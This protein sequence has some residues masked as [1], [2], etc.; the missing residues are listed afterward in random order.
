[1][2]GKHHTIESKRKIGEANKIAL[3]G[4]KQ[5]KETINK[6]IESR[7]WYKHS[8]DTKKKIGNA[9]K[10]NM[11]GFRQKENTKKKIGKTIR[12]L[13]KDNKYKEKMHKALLGRK[14]SEET[15]IKI[16]KARKGKKH[17]D[18]TKQKLSKA[19]KGLLSKEKH[20]NWRGGKSFEPYSVDWTETL[21]RSIRERDNY[22]CQLCNQ[23]GNNVHHIDYDKKNC[24]TYNLITLCR[25]CNIKVNFNRDYWKKYFK[26]V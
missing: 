11:I 18:K 15:R 8:E 14:V 13:W 26:E 22:I 4:K 21:R 6:R 25:K 5:S 12:N 9:N 17:T 1:M 7:K 16:S 24:N 10:I 19:L 3:K 23:Y 2:L 20:P